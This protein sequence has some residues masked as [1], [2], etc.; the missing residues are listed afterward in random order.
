MGDR[1]AWDYPPFISTDGHNVP[2]LKDTQNKVAKFTASTK[3][4]CTNSGGTTDPYTI[5]LRSLVENRDDTDD[6]FSHILDGQVTFAERIRRITVGCYIAAVAMTNTSVAEE[7]YSSQDALMQLYPNRPIDVL[8]LL[9]HTVQPD[10]ATYLNYHI[11]ELNAR[12]AGCIAAFTDALC[13]YAWG[14]PLAAVRERLTA[15]MTSKN[16]FDQRFDQMMQQ[17]GNTMPRNIGFQANQLFLQLEMARVHSRLW[18]IVG[19]RVIGKAASNAAP[20]MPFD[21]VLT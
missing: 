8:S 17:F 9:A 14:E 21:L 15:Y 6:E 5:M 4:L 13:Q 11:A 7:T 19:G 18:S 3:R 10:A 2:L 1:I 20:G 16:Q 12:A